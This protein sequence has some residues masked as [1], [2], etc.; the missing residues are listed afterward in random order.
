MTSTQF[1]YTFC[2]ALEQLDVVTL[3][4]LIASNSAENTLTIFRRLCDITHTN[5]ICIGFSSYIGGTELI[6]AGDSRLLEKQQ[7]ELCQRPI[8]EFF[9][10]LVETVNRELIERVYVTLEDYALSHKGKFQENFHKFILEN[11][12]IK[13]EIKTAAM[14]RA[15]MAYLLNILENSENFENINYVFQYLCLTESETYTNEIKK[16]LKDSIELDRV[17]NDMGD[18]SCLVMPSRILSGFDIL[19]ECSYDERKI[20]LNT[21]SRHVDLATRNRLKF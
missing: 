7:F 21:D 5:A 18:D 12:I 11:P 6:A 8:S 14:Q 9:D 4:D 16:A 20:L 3:R 15:A 2:E 1:S 13:L 10:W 17:F 19:L